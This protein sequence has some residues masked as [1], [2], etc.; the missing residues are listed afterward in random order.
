VLRTP[1]VTLLPLAPASSARK[2]LRALPLPLLHDGV[3]PAI[4]VLFRLISGCHTL[5]TSHA[6][7]SSLPAEAFPPLPAREG[8]CSLGQIPVHMK[9]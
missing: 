8:E 1:A 5:L 4:R 3:R 9:G 2:R 7:G 6:S